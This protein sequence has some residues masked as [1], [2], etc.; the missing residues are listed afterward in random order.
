MSAS[1]EDGAAQMCYEVM[2]RS[3]G[4]A[5]V[6]WS[7]TTKETKDRWEEVVQAIGERVDSAI[8]AARQQGAVLP[9]G[10]DLLEAAAAAGAAEA[11]GS[12]WIP[13]IQA[14]WEAMGKDETRAWREVARAMDAVMGPRLLDHVCKAPPLTPAQEDQILATL[15]RF[16]G[17]KFEP[18]DYMAVLQRL[19]A[20]VGAG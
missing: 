2:S 13:D 5:S 3:A 1:W 11:C 7:K 18:S 15:V 12:G 20:A 8:L 10:E 9:P 17:S 19:R 14:C 4:S 16:S 6:D